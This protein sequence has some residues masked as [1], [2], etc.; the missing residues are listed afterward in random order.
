MRIMQ[1]I[2]CR[3]FS[4]CFGRVGPNGIVR[5]PNS[6]PNN[7]QNQFYLVEGSV[8]VADEALNEI[9]LPI[10]QWQDLSSFKNSSRLT[11]TVGPNGCSW[12][13]ILPQ[14]NDKEYDVEMIES[15][16]VVPQQDNSFLLITEGEEVT[17][18]GLQTKQLNYAMLTKD[19]NVVR[20]G[21][22][23]AKFTE[24]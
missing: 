8:H 1:H 24:R 5:H 2:G 9:N 13:L 4:I 19:I 14:P 18:N 23:V 7:T 10:K 12:V 16:G 20:N 11:Y 22:V 6:M 21:G 15:D 17:F 3:G